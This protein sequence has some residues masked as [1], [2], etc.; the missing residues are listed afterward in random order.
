MPDD[1]SQGIA[2]RVSILEQKN[3]E[4]RVLLSCLSSY[5]SSLLPP[6]QKMGYT[7]HEE[8]KDAFHD[9]IHIANRLWEAEQELQKLG[10]FIDAW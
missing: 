4:L 9:H 3:E 8:N 5:L 7:Y 2:Q 6:I 10:Q 1:S